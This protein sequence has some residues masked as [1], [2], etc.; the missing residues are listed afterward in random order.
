MTPNQLLDIEQHFK[1]ILETLGLDLNDPNFAQTPARVARSYKEI[2]RG[3]SPDSEK[4]ME[5]IL[6]TTFPAD[7]N[8]MITF[9]NLDVWS[10]CPHHFLP[11]E[12]KIN[13]AYIPNNV[14]IG[15][16]KIPRVIELLAARP[17]L[18]EQLTTDIVKTLDRSLK[19][20]GCIV[21]ITGQ[22]LCM[23]IRGVKTHNSTISTTAYLG[24]F[25]NLV[26]RTEF[27]DSIR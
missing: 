5:K 21:H 15:L 4:E 3:L 16:S 20:K 11:V 23:K 17:I 7:Y 8:E 10:V 1:S 25:E 14:V 26:S 2:F 18:Q 22:H 12:M 24:C 9:R 13:F 19:S 6:N 27:F